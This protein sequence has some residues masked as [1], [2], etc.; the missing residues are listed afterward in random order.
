MSVFTTGIRCT[1]FGVNPHA[2]LLCPYC[3]QALQLSGEKEFW[4]RL[5]DFEKGE[6]TLQHFGETVTNVPAEGWRPRP[7]PG[8][9]AMWKWAQE[10]NRCFRHAVHLKNSYRKHTGVDVDLTL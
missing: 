10:S 5:E 3:G 2:N 9:V 4:K 1:F 7:H 8:Y 6:Y